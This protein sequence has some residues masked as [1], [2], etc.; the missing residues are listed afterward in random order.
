MMTR[1]YI[2]T[3]LGE[4]LTQFFSFYK[5]P[6]KSLVAHYAMVAKKVNQWC[7]EETTEPEP[8]DYDLGTAMWNLK[9]FKDGAPIDHESL[10]PKN[11]ALVLTIVTYIKLYDT[12]EREEI[13]SL[14]DHLNVLVVGEE[15]IIDGLT[16]PKDIT[17]FSLFDIL[18]GETTDEK[19]R[20]KR[21]L[22]T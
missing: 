2:T 14:Q 21:E 5:D 13:E 17:L 22:I 7:G 3:S 8:R 9:C 15:V 16:I 20:I 1:P 18:N 10:N 19:L 12:P 4:L 6:S 11:I